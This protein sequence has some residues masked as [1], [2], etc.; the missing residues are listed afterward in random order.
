M[1]IHFITIV[2]TVAIGIFLG[3]VGFGGQHFF[4]VTKAVTIHILLKRIGF[5]G[6]QLI[7]IA[8]AVAVGVGFQ[9]IGVVGDR[10]FF[11]IEAVAVGIGFGR[12]GF[13]LI[14]F[15]AVIEAVAVGVGHHWIGLILHDFFTVRQAVAVGIGII[16]IGTQFF[17]LAIGQTVAVG[18]GIPVESRH[19]Q[20]GHHAQEVVIGILL[21]GVEVVGKGHIITT[22]HFKGCHIIQ[23][24]L[25]TET[26]GNVRHP[27]LGGVIL[28]AVGGGSGFNIIIDRAS[29]GVDIRTPGLV[30]KQ[31]EKQP[32]I[33]RAQSGFKIFVF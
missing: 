21:D 11:V 20:T 6:H 3:K 2:E 15:F 30:G 26:E 29:A 28:S 33:D 4:T 10:F 14:H 17:F 19:G 27:S 25:H 13:V 12:I 18:I 32:C 8:E 23:A 1:L 31:P 5:V 24:E 22:A 16:H 9:R 7:L